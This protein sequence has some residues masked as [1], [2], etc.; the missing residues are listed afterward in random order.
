[1]VAATLSPC[2]ARL[3]HSRPRQL[4]SSTRQQQPQREASQE[5]QQQ[6]RRQLASSFGST[7]RGLWT[8]CRTRYPPVTPSMPRPCLAIQRLLLPPMHASAPALHSCS[9]TEHPP[10]PHQSSFRRRYLASTSS[11]YSNPCSILGLSRSSTQPQAWGAAGA[12]PPRTSTSSRK[13]SGSLLVQ[14]PPS[15][16]PPKQRSPHQPQRQPPHTH[17]RQPNRHR[18]QRSPCSPLLAVCCP[19]G[20]PSGMHKG[21]FN[22]MLI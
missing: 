18:S 5:R 11:L 1:M 3:R 10:Y 8:A 17:T 16:I 13:D 9:W 19:L 20:A 22:R 21:Q 15:S 4:L 12:C 6:H 14:Q 7:L 2:P